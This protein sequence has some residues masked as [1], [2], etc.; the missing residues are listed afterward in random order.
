LLRKSSSKGWQPEF[1][2]AFALSTSEFW[3]S[4]ERHCSHSWQT[5]YGVQDGQHTLSFTQR[6]S[7]VNF[8]VT[9]MHVLLQVA[10]GMIKQ[11]RGLKSREEVL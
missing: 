11:F 8:S 4:R 6:C 9:P 7:G 2:F 10:V 1:A 3:A 5:E